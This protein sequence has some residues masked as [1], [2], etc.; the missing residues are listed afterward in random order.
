[1][2]LTNFIRTD[3]NYLPKER[4]EIMTICSLAMPVTDHGWHRALGCHEAAM[5]QLAITV[6]AESAQILKR[7]TEVV[8]G[9]V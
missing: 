3:S 2:V 7:E 6:R 9:A 4:R 5:F 8:R 1:M